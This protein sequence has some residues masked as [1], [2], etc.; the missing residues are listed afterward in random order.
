MGRQIEKSQPAT[1]DGV[2]RAVAKKILSY[3]FGNWFYSVKQ[4]G[5]EFHVILLDTVKDDDGNWC[6]VDKELIKD[7]QQFFGKHFYKIRIIK[8]E[9][10]L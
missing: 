5:F 2:T 4:E 6:D 3:V 10:I 1:I 7:F 9:D 8:R